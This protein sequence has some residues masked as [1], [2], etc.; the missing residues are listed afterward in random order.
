MSSDDPPGDGDGP[1]LTDGLHSLTPTSP[2][3][4]PVPMPRAPGFPESL[5]PH[6]DAAVRD[7]PAAPD[8]PPRARHARR[9]PLHHLHH[10]L[11]QV[12]GRKVAD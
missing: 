3:S 9:L 11:H 10:Q 5:A 4:A 7:G 2:A 8:A 12:G 1:P 6:L